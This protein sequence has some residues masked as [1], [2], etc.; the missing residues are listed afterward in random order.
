V[1]CDKKDNLMKIMIRN[2]KKMQIKDQGQNLKGKKK[3]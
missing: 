3:S 2:K 1:G